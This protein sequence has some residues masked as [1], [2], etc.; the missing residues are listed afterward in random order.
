MTTSSN[1]L[2]L[3][4]TD[5]MALRDFEDAQ[6]DVETDPLH[7]LS[8]PEIVAECDEYDAEEAAYW[9]NERYLLRQARHDEYWG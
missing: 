8:W 1:D 7:G 5:A 2:F 3:R 9:E 6:P 4:I